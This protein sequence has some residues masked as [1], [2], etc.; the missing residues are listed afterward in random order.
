MARASDGLLLLAATAPLIGILLLWLFWLVGSKLM[1]PS[2]HPIIGWMQADEYY[3]ILVPL[4][5][6][7]ITLLA[8]YLLWFTNSLFRHN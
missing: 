3:C 6:L 4:T 7:P 2:E 1:P 8:R 5:L